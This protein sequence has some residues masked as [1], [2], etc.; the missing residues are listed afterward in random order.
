MAT[1]GYSV[2]YTPLDDDDDDE[3]I[4]DADS[5]AS[6]E[7]DD[8]VFHLPERIL[9]EL[10]SKNGFV[11]YLVKWRDCPVIRSSWEG[12]ISWEKYPG[13][14]DD[15][16]VEK[17]RQ[18][19]GE[20]KPLDITAFNNAVLRV[21]VAERQRRILRRLKRRVNRVISIVSA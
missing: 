16:E 10:H 9:A 14:F 1:V 2:V 3:G 5:I 4:A 20:S 12:D 21:E 6:N 13:I 8:G 15:W 18:E 11:W 17:R 7:T 19:R